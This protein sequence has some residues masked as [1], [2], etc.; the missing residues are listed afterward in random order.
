MEVVST[1]HPPARLALSLNHAQ[2]WDQV[3][4][5]F[6]APKG[7]IEGLLPWLQG[8]PAQ[9]ARP[10]GYSSSTLPAE[11]Y[12]HIRK[13]MKPGSGSGPGGS[14]VPPGYGATG[15]GGGMD[16]R[17]GGSH[18]W[19]AGGGGADDT[20]RRR[21][22]GKPRRRFAVGPLGESQ[23]AAPAGDGSLSGPIVQPVAPPSPPDYS[24]LTEAEL[25]RLH[26]ELERQMAEVEK[27]EAAAARRGESAA[28]AREAAENAARRRAEGT[29]AARA[30][31][32]AARAERAM[33]E[34]EEKAAAAAAKFKDRSER[35]ALER[36]DEARGRAEELRQ[37]LEA[38]IAELTKPTPPMEQPMEK[39]SRL[40]PSRGE[41]SSGA[42]ERTR[43][44]RRSERSAVVRAPKKTRT[45]E[46]KSPPPPPQASQDRQSEDSS[47]SGQNT[48]GLQQ[49]ESLH[50]QRLV[51]QV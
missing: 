47:R 46:A 12:W 9:N 51:R 30:R 34:A 18:G 11:A 4:R 25:A 42:A 43:G 6:L 16:G 29:A 33:L 35:Y 45:K 38:G 3:T 31:A 22:F 27:A 14:F 44:F 8:S 5:A 41:G 48:A 36:L 2:V 26:K 1:N 39:G 24:V 40:L 49:Q 23:P 28:V 37:K 32:A 15:G 20:S 7:G 17:Y 13:D 19:A 10:R 50:Q 21:V